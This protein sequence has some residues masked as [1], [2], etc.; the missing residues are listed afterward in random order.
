[1][2]SDWQMFREGDGIG[3]WGAFVCKRGSFLCNI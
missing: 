1:M 2:N 3:N